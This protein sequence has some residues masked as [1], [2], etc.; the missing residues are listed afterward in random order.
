[1]NRRALLCATLLAATALASG[2]GWSAPEEG[3]ASSAPTLDIEAL[4]YDPATPVGGNPKGDV[5]IVA[6]F[7]YNCGYCRTSMADLETLLREDGGIR[8]VYKDWPILAASSVSAAQFALGAKYQG[9]YEAAHRALMG[10]TGRVTDSS[11]QKALD[12]AEIDRAKLQMDMRANA[13]EIGAL[14][15]RNNRQ[16]EALQLPG[17]PVYLIGPYKV[18]AALDLAGFREVVKDA[19]ARAA[20]K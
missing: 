16:A 10:L 1:M 6:F 3:A 17:T 5:T 15:K 14:L 8:L 13:G 2:D 9:K 4:L 7:D 11:I 18:A 19:R 12:T 20:E